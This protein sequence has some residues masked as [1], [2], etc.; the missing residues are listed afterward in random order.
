VSGGQDF[1]DY[2][3]ILGVPFEASRDHI[4]KAHK[5]LTAFSHPDF[6]MRDPKVEAWANERMKQ[7]DE[8]R[9]VLLDPGKRAEYDSTYDER[10]AAHERVSRQGPRPKEARERCPVCE[11]R[12]SFVCPVCSGRGTD[13][14]PGC[15]GTRTVVCP[16][17][18]GRGSIPE[19]EYWRYVAGDERARRQA[20]ATAHQQAVADTERWHAA[21]AR[22]R[23]NRFAT[24]SWIVFL[25]SLTTFLVV[26]AGAD[27]AVQQLVARRLS[28]PASHARPE[29][30]EVSIGGSSEQ[31]LPSVRS[32]ESRNSVEYRFVNQTG[33]TL[34]VFW[35]DYG[36]KEI[37]STTLQA[38]RTWAVA[39][40]VTHPW[41]FRDAQT[42]RVA[43]TVVAKARNTEVT[44]LP[45]KR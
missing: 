43:F 36:G 11:G 38:G 10:K 6:F 33:R 2:Y 13:E 41:R 42:G 22:I 1:R 4:K 24:V 27:R 3:E 44:L 15:A 25:I 19:A 17:C 9:D 5:H 20:E 21:E 32:L 28:L 8:A 40:Y 14:C 18:H 23:W 30:T 34:K 26:R 39:T 37:Y 16:I 12:G 31:S 7:I 35:I 45:P 29:S